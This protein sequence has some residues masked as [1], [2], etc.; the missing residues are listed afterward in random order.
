MKDIVEKIVSELNKDG[1]AQCHI[2]E[3]LSKKDLKKFDR[4]E[5]FY[6]EFRNHY[7]IKE[8]FSKLKDYKKLKSELNLINELCTSN[9]INTK[10]IIVSPYGIESLGDEI[11][12]VFY[13]I[14]SKNQI[15][16]FSKDSYRFIKG[17]YYEFS[18]FRKHIG[19]EFLRKIYE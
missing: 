13:S 2:S 10:L 7:K 11:L 3:L 19:D 6:N 9:S 18:H 15:Y 16:D 14:F 17:N 5:N 8:N 12:N 1:F 4:L